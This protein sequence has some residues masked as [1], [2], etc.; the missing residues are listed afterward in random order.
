[1]NIWKSFCFLIET[2]DGVSKTIFEAIIE[3]F[4]GEFAV[5][6]NYYREFRKNSGKYS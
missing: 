2:P 4:P 1:M 5:E 6:N 3:L